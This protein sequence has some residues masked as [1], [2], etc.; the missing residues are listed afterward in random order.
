MCDEPKHGEAD[1]QDVFN[2]IEIGLIFGGQ[3]VNV[4]SQLSG[5]RYWPYGQLP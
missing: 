3:Y 1:D 2:R 5:A 4:S